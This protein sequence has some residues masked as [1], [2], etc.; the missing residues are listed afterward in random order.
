MK[1]FQVL[2]VLEETGIAGINGIVAESCIQKLL[3]LR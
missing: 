2:Q 3:F 1:H